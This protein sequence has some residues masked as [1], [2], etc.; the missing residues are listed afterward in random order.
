MSQNTENKSY[1]APKFCCV[2]VVG[3][4]Q[5]AFI[6]T[7]GERIPFGPAFNKSQDLWR[8]QSENGVSNYDKL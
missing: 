4:W 3:G 2:S 7:S 6:T 1:K 8:W 5:T